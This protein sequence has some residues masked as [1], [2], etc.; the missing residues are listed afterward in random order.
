MDLSWAASY[1]EGAWK[2]SIK[3]TNALI[4]N[5]L[6]GFVSFLGKVLKSKSKELC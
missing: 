3:K 2:S 1:T 6:V 4:S 5:Y